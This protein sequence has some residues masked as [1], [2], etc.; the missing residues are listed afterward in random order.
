MIRCTIRLLIKIRLYYLF[1]LIH[2]VYKIDFLITS[3]TLFGILNFSNFA[4]NFIISL[5][6]NFLFL[7]KSSNNSWLLYS[8]NSICISFMSFISAFYVFLYFFFLLLSL[9]SL[10]LFLLQYR[11]SPKISFLCFQT[12][13]IYPTIPIH[14]LLSF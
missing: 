5:I 7:F 3:I 12:L 8:I 1:C 6:I 4:S 9:F 2:N 11:L 13:V 14:Q 10:I